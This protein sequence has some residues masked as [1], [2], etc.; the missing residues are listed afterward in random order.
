M[1]HTSAVDTD[2]IAGFD[3]VLNMDWLSDNQAHIFSNRKG[4]E[5]ITSD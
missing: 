1:C 3:I 2:Q 4:V 5:I